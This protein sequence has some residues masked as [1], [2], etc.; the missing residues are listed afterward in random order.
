MCIR[1]VCLNQ[2]SETR[3]FPHVHPKHL[4]FP[5]TFN[6]IHLSATFSEGTGKP[7]V[8]LYNNYVTLILHILSLVGLGNTTGFKLILQ[9]ASWALKQGGIWGDCY[10]SPSRPATGSLE[11]TRSLSAQHCSSHQCLQKPRRFLLSLK[12]PAHPKP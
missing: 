4:T 10:R 6:F 8:P 1:N 7:C 3:S 11:P 2:S 9:C 12:D 5:P